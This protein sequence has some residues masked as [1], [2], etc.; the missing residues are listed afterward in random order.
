L[1]SLFA[2]EIIDSRWQ[3][4]PL[5]LHV[6]FGPIRTIP[7]GHT[8][9]NPRNPVW[10]R[11]RCWQCGQNLA[12]ILSIDKDRP[13]LGFEPQLSCCFNADQFIKAN[14]LVN[15]RVLP[16]ALSDGNRLMSFFSNGETDECASLID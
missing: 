1:E 6:N 5:S 13:Y 12:K 16:I 3:G 2:L 11:Y 7:S 15:A 4:T 9:S 8:S 10:N 14:D